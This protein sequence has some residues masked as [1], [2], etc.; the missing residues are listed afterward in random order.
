M[1]NKGLL[2]AGER[3]DDL[4]IG[5]IKIIQHPDGFCF[6]LDAIL[7]G[8]F[9]CVKKGCRAVD[10]GTGTGV[11]A[12]VLSARGA[13]EVTGI[14]LNPDTADRA[15]RS[16]ALNGLEEKVAL[17]CG[18]LRSVRQFL[19]SG[20]YDLVVSNPPYRSLGGGFLNPAQGLA[21]ARHETTA[22]LKDVL[23]AARY[24]LKYRGRFAMVHLPERM[25]DIISGMREAGIEPKRLRL[26]HSGIHKKPNMLLVEGIRGAQ[27]GL[28]VLPPLIVYGENG[29]YTQEILGYYSQEEKG[30]V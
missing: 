2:K 13:S 8:H 15:A 28:E 17:Q 24:L 23:A 25:T 18:D 6:S 5:G 9:A 30:G 20:Q 12:F 19:P 21:M 7:L 11:I 16:A 29:Q 14:E 4:I 27:P 1:E 26:V 10:L 3:L 22:S